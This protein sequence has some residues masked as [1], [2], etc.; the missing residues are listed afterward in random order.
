MLGKKI[1]RSKMAPRERK[2]TPPRTMKLGQEK[3]VKQMM[4]RL[5]RRMKL[6][7]ARNATLMKMTPHLTK[8]QDVEMKM[9]P[10][11][12]TQSDEF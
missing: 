6:V 5:P 9:V 8:N 7:R 12:R 10:S 4:M 1:Q 11:M 3:S 2:R